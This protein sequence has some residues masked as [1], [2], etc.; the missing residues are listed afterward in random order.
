MYEAT[1]TNNDDIARSGMERVADIQRPIS[2]ELEKVYQGL[3][4]EGGIWAKCTE[5]EIEKHRYFPP[6]LPKGDFNVPAIGESLNSRGIPTGYFVTFKKEPVLLLPSVLKALYHVKHHRSDRV[7]QGRNA[8]NY[9][10][11]PEMN[12]IT[13]KVQWALPGATAQAELGYTL[14]E[15]DQEKREPYSEILIVCDEGV[16]V[17]ASRH[18]DG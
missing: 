10:C 2:K 3:G 16:I 1:D 5:S 14:S 6:E 7:Q 17:T 11:Y 13:T 4:M 18:H 8:G 15:I 12:I 9:S